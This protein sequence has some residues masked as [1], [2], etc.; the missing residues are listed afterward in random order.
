MIIKSDMVKKI[1]LI[2]LNI[3]S[4]SFQL[5]LW[6]CNLSWPQTQDPP[7]S[8]SQVLGLQVC[9]CIPCSYSFC[10]SK[11]VRV[12]VDICTKVFLS[13]ISKA[14]ITQMDVKIGIS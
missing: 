13:I 5:F 6:P 8:A 1:G 2:L 9:I 12:G 14:V 7:A 3:A 11:S 4:H 10:K